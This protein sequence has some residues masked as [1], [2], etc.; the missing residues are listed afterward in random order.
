M[1]QSFLCLCVQKL[2]WELNSAK[3]D[4]LEAYATRGILKG[5]FLCGVIGTSASAASASRP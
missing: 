4:V 5:I 2:K 3:L 1:E